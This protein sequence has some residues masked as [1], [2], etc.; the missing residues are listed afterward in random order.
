MK[1]YRRYPPEGGPVSLL[2][3]LIVVL[4]V[5]AIIYLIRRS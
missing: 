2:Y 4:V 1:P 5:V 3:I